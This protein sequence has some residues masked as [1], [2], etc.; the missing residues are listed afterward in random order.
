MFEFLNEE[1]SEN[2][3]EQAD[4]SEKLRRLPAPSPHEN[5]PSVLGRRDRTRGCLADFA[6]DRARRSSAPRQRPRY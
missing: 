4:K 1:I 6:C 3:A 5:T 2:R